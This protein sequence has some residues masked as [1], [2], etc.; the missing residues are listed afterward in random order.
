MATTERDLVGRRIGDLLRERREELGL[1]LE[2]VAGPAGMTASGYWLLEQGDRVPRFD[3]LLR[4]LYALGIQ[5]LSAR[6]IVEMEW[7]QVE[8][9]SGLPGLRLVVV[10]EPQVDETGA[11]RTLVKSAA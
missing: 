9:A 8:L 7:K 11:T 6:Q 3:T 4:V 2:Q 5:D 1:T 10:D